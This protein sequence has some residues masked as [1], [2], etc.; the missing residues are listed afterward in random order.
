MGLPSRPEVS[1]PRHAGGWGLRAGGTR[2]ER[3]GQEW[4]WL[5]P[6]HHR[7][8]GLKRL[9][10]QDA[11]LLLGERL[12]ERIQ[13]TRVPGIEGVWALRAKAGLWTSLPP[14]ACCQMWSDRLLE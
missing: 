8:A 9:A 2:G 6:T 11:A 4:P 7:V 10:E 14:N 13:D 5:G 1:L 12:S 3:W